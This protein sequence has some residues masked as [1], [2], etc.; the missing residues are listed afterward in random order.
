M[1]TENFYFNMSVPS[2]KVKAELEFMETFINFAKH[3]I[4]TAKTVFIKKEF[5]ECNYPAVTATAKLL[6]ANQMDVYIEPFGIYDI[7]IRGLKDGKEYY[8]ECELIKAWEYST[9]EKFYRYDDAHVLGRKWHYRDYDNAFLCTV[10]AD[11]GGLLI[12]PFELLKDD[13]WLWSRRKEIKTE[14]H[15]EGEYVCRIDWKNES[16]KQYL[17]K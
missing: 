17:K 13:A 11:L 9:R 4:Q 14:R 16:T 6:E 15:P 8:F 5:E 3:V 7:D 12:T 2:P 1:A 10:R